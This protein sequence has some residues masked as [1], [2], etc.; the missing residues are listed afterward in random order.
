MNAKAKQFLFL[1]A[2]A[3]FWFSQ[4]VYT[5]YFTPYMSSLGIAASLAG[6]IVGAYGFTQLV[7]R[8]PF[9]VAADF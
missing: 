4:Y 5:S 1:V 9:G 7:L 2:V 6:T 3:L 8:I